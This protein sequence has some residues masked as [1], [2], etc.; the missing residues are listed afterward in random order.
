[1]DPLLALPAVVEAGREVY[2]GGVDLLSFEPIILF[3][4]DPIFGE[5]DAA[6]IWMLSTPAIY[7][8]P[9]E[10]LMTSKR[11]WNNFH[12]RYPILTNFVDERNTRHIKWLKW[13]GC[14]FPRRVERFGA[15]GLPFLEFVSY[16]PCVT[17]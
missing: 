8:F 10:F 11:V 14:V 3:G 9:V 16:R 17:H 12:D 2:V 15:S 4:I 1:V 7:D 5:T 6:T 13:M